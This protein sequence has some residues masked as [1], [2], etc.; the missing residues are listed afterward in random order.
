MFKIIK[1]QHH[2]GVAPKIPFKPVERHSHNITVMYFSATWNTA[3]LYPQLVN[4]V[5][6]VFVEMRRV[7]SQ[8]YDVFDAAGFNHF[9]GHLPSRLFRQPFPR[10]AQ[11]AGLFLNGHL[12]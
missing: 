5:N 8:I 4:K 1:V 3:H 12:R 11:L 10:A 2:I 6:V 7:C 9:K